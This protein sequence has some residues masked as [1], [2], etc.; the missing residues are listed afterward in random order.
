MP[1]LWPVSV[2]LSINRQHWLCSPV[3][4]LS[5]ASWFK[6]LYIPGPLGAE[7]PFPFQ[8]GLHHSHGQRWG[9]CHAE[10]TL[11]WSQGQPGL[12][13]PPWTGRLFFEQCQA[14]RPAPEKS[15]NQTPTLTS[16]PP[17]QAY[18][19]QALPHR[20]PEG[21]PCPPYLLLPPEGESLCPSGDGESSGMSEMMGPLAL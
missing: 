1:F 12:A 15:F 8:D 13:I 2:D 11:V 17:P 5:G 20:V 10:V 18:G 3:R 7:A 6:L 14:L 21:S 9:C 19:L 4:Y 16:P